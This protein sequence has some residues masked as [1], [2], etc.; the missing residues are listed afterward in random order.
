MFNFRR[1]FF[2]CFLCRGIDP[3]IHFI[4]PQQIEEALSSGLTIML[5][6]GTGPITG[7]N[8]TT[9][10]PSVWNI[11]RMLEAAEIQFAYNH[12]HFTFCP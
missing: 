1:A 8:A 2:D 10:D 7:A 9:C 12:R 11:H 3:H 4:C 5:G 6:S